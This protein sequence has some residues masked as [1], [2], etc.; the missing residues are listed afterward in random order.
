MPAVCRSGG[1]EW[2]QRSPINY[3]EHLKK[4]EACIADVVES[5][6]KGQKSSASELLSLSSFSYIL[7]LESVAHL[8]SIESNESLLTDSLEEADTASVLWKEIRSWNTSPEKEVMTLFY[9]PTPLNQKEIA[10]KLALSRSKVCRLHNK[11]I[12]K[13]K[14]RMAH[15]LG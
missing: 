10:E 15:L 13:L 6:M 12:E 9:G 2:K 3:K 5:T 7:S 8:S 4:T 11:G 1:S 14:R